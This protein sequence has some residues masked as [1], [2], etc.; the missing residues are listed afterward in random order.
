MSTTVDE[1]VVEMRF[2][3]K[4]FEQNIQTSF[5]R[6]VK[7]FEMNEIADDVIKIIS[8]GCEIITT[9]AKLD[10]DYF[11]MFDKFIND[12]SPLVSEVVSFS[13]KE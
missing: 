6:I 1:R 8:K 3:N 11:K 13:Y 10:D 5:D 4:Q 12:E 9:K 2:D 7:V